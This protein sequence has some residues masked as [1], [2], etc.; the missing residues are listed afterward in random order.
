MSRYDQLLNQ[1]HSRPKATEKPTLA[2]MRTLMHRLGDPQD[3]L[4]FIHIT[5]T[6][7]KGSTA[8]FTA[9]VLRETGQKIGLFTSPFLVNFRERFQI[10]GVMISKA[11]FSDFAEQVLQAEADTGVGPINEFEFVT[12]VGFCWFAAQCCSWVVLEAG[13]GG[14]DDPTNI[15]TT[16]VCCCI[17]KISLDHTALLGSTVAA[18]AENKAG[19]LRAGI[20]LVTPCSQV[21]AALEVLQ[22]VAKRHHAP[23]TVT[24][25]PQ[26]YDCRSDGSHMLYGTLKLDIPLPGAHQL[27]NTACAVEICKC[28]GCTDAQ[29]SAGI[30]TAVWPGR[31]QI[32]SRAPFVL[33]DAGHNPDGIASLCQALDTLY[34]DYRL[35]IIMTMMQDKQYIP[36]IEALASRAA[37]FYACTLPMP[38]ALRPEQVALAAAP[39]CGAVSLHSSLLQALQAAKPN[40]TQKDLLVICGSVYLAGEAINIFQSG[41]V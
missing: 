35:Q 27:E 9:S 4:R 7:G 36:C 41:L 8:A 13:M 16:S 33:T 20:P 31:L 10:N 34:Q 29:I 37:R 30:A 40:L 6:N 12:A 38:R 32:L 22:Q 15:I 24:A 28:L 5:G 11:E 23:L 14:R 39:C 25:K 18:I 19:I 17:T 1:L 2:R 26:Q 21:P 3:R